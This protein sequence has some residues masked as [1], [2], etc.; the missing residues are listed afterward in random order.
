MQIGAATVVMLAVLPLDPAPHLH[1]T[2]RLGVAL[3]ITSLLGTAA[4]FTIQSYAQQHLPP[5]TTAVTLTLEPVFACATS[6]VVLGERMSPRSITGA[7][8]ILAGIA[9]IELLGHAAQTTEIP[10]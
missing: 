9:G 6:M 2:A 4:A 1:W 7:A 5:A 8:L 10:A 3:A